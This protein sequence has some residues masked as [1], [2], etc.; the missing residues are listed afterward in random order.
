MRKVIQMS[1][2]QIS[3]NGEEKSMSLQEVFL[4]NHSPSHTKERERMI[5]AI[6]Y[7]HML[8]TIHEI[9]LDWVIG[10]NV[11]GIL[12]MVQPGRETEVGS[13]STLF[14]ES[15][16]VFK[17]RQQYVVETI[18]RDLERE[19]Y[20][21]QPVLIPACSVGA[22]HRR[23]RVW[24]I[25]H[26]DGTG[27]QAQVGQQAAGTTGDNPWNASAN[28]SGNRDTPCRKSRKWKSMNLSSPHAQI[29]GEKNP[30][31]RRIFWTF[32]GYYRNRYRTILSWKTRTGTIWKNRS[33]NGWQKD[34]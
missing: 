34:K 16:P 31:Y 21:V 8:S 30:N 6:S 33:Y 11:A 9:G 7:S 25:A 18:C 19:G 29:A 3:W 22:P 1:Q 2:R 26:R 20:S 24:F 27:L 4:V 10:E 32:T 17:R 13:Q 28:A 23:D 5:T 15:E 12:T 14:G